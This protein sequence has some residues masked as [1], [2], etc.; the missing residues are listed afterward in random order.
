MYQ[1][2]KRNYRY[3][4]RLAWSKLVR[5]GNIFSRPY[6]PEEFAFAREWLDFGGWIPWEEISSVLCLAAGGGQQGPLFASLGCRVTVLDLSLAQ[7]QLDCKV[8]KKYGFDIECIQGDM[9]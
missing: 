2:P 6:G 4:N 8:A 3:V 9:L 5:Q 1:D 7:L